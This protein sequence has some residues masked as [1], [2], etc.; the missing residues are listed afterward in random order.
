MKNVLYLYLAFIFFTSLYLS[1]KNEAQ[2]QNRR[3]LPLRVMNKMLISIKR[4]IISIFYPGLLLAQNLFMFLL[5]M[6][7]QAQSSCHI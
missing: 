7:W 2:I 5:K 1:I 4:N 6:K 3:N